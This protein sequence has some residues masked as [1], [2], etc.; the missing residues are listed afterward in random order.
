MLMFERMRP[1]FLF[2]AGESVTL[3]KWLAGCLAH[4]MGSLN[5]ARYDEATCHSNQRAEQRSLAA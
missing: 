5:D 4:F 1:H 3:A 2:Q